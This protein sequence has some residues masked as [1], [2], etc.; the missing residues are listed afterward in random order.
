MTYKIGIIC[1]GDREVAPFLPLLTDCTVSEKAMLKFYSGK[2]EGVEVVTLFS[3]VC[4]TNAAIPTQILIDTYGC[5]VVINAGTCGGM[6][7]NVKLFDTIIS[8]ESAYW[9]V[10]GEILTSF[11]PWLETIYFKADKTLLD[12]AQRAVSKLPTGYP[13][14][15]LSTPDSPPR[16]Y[17]GRMITGESFIEDKYRDEI[18]TN[19]SPL[20]VDMETAAVAHVCYVNSIP[21]IAVRTVTDTAEHVG[22]DAFDKNC[23]KASQISAGIVAAILKE[24]SNQME[25]TKMNLQLI[26]P[27]PEHK[28][29]ALDYIKE[30]AD[31]GED[32]IHGS[33]SITKS[34]SYEAWLRKIASAQ[35]SAPP[36]F[37]IADTYFAVVDGRI[38]GTIQVRHS[39]TE[40][41]LQSGGHIGYGVRPTERRKG[42]AT[43]MLTLALQRCRE[44]GIEKALITCDEDNTGSAKTIEKCGGLFENTAID[45]DGDVLR[46]YWI[47]L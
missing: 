30:H 29:A 41:L 5:N 24:M 2:L 42:Y 45:E 40:N 34:D 1:A 14:S 23:E 28:Q 43:Q 10:V 21:F 38:V 25:Q 39:L 20:C 4:K 8:T 11:H 37:V 18:N 16:I 13:T 26:L 47:T 35:T 36:G 12:F 15:T 32:H 27:T 17:F 19:F 46:R 33:S 3:G 44:L 6:A 7:T 22:G 9:D 31:N